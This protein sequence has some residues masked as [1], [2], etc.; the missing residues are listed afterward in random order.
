MRDTNRIEHVPLRL[1]VAMADFVLEGQNALGAR[2]HGLLRSIGLLNNE[3]DVADFLVAIHWVHDLD[4]YDVL[5][6]TNRNSITDQR[7]ILCFNSAKFKL[8]NAGNA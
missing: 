4:R 7:F 5:E 3:V 2:T 6:R 1:K 8:F